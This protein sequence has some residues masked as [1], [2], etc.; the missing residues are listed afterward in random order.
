VQLDLFQLR[1]VNVHPVKFVSTCLPGAYLIELERREDE[2]GFFARFFCCR[3][4]A[5]HGLQSQI[6]QINTSFS[7]QR[8]T[9]RG[10][11]YQ[12]PPRAEDKVIR[13]LR[14]AIFDAIVDLRP[15]SPTYLKYL[16]VHLDEENRRMLYVP[17]GFAHGFLTLAPN[18]EVLYLVTEF[19]C[20]ELERGIRYD[21]AALSIPWPEK[22]T[23]ISAKDASLP[24]FDPK[25]HQAEFLLE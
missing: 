5:E 17:K 12:L 11:H 13:C 15:N 22:P 19:Y 1:H 20:A 2:R 24:P 8:G 7:R 14:G 18:T 6:V 25:R 9:L 16:T 4:F 21:D 3:E 10:M 23:V